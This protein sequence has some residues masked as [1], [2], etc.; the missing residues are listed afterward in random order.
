MKLV[1]FML[2]FILRKVININI[3]S[4]EHEMHITTGSI[5]LNVINVQYINLVT[6]V[7]SNVCNV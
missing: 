5:I 3:I 6:N 7:P 4:K 2:F 1:I